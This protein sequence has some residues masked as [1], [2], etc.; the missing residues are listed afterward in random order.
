M[1]AQSPRKITA[2]A[3][4]I[5]SIA[6][7]PSAAPMITMAVF[8]NSSGRVASLIPADRD[9]KKLPTTRPA[10][11]ARRNPASPVRLSDHPM[12]SLASLSGVAAM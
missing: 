12:P 1:I 4:V 7:T 2:L 3:R 5:A 9:G 11:R 10:T 8:M 6:F